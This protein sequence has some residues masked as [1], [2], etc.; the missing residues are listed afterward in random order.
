[1]N[2]LWV[3]I[4]VMFFF[5]GLL[6][7]TNAPKVS[8]PVHWDCSETAYYT[9]T[10]EQRLN[11]KP[12]LVVGYTKDYAHAWVENEKGEVIVGGDKKWLYETFP[13]R[14]YYN[15]TIPKNDPFGYSWES[16]WIIYL[17]NRK[18]GSDQN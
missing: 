4:W 11:H 8:L 5:F 6:P 15:K 2:K 12:V 7:I 18:A 10:N 1:M 13:D 14:Y 17:D 16:E 3:L 9:F